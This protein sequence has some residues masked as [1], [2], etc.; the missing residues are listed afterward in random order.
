M[1]RKKLNK[2][3]EPNKLR[4]AIIGDPD[5][6]KTWLLPHHSRESGDLGTTDSLDIE[7]T[8]DWDAMPDVI[9]LLTGI[10]GNRVAAP[11]EIV[12]EAAKHLAEHYQEAKRPIPD[13]LAALI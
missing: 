6:P 5:D 2:P 13:A 9:A 10:H 1:K 3:N 7:K 4:F 12:I 8:V 11:P